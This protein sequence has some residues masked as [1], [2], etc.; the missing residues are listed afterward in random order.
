MEA[1]VDIECTFSGERGR[2]KHLN[3]RNKRNGTD[4]QK[5]DD[6]EEME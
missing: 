4:S 1:P 6:M 2:L 3:E 5:R